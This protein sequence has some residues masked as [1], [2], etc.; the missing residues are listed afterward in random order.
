MAVEELTEML[1]DEVTVNRYS[2][3]HCPITVS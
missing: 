2:P 1:T 3:L